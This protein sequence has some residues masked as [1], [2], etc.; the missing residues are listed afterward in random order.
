MTGWTEFAQELDCW[1]DQRRAAIFWWR[2]DDAVTATP[3]LGRLMAL[4]QEY[5]VPVAIAVIPARADETLG[6]PIADG[7]NCVLQHGYAHRNHGIGRKIELGGERPSGEVAEELLLGR[8]KL[9]DLLGARVLPVLV[10]PW[11]RIDDS[12]AALLP[13]LGYAGLSAFAPRR[14]RGVDG[15]VT[16]NTHIDIIDWRK[17]RAFCGEHAALSAAI[18]HLSAKRAGSA[19]PLEPTGLLTHHLA[20]DGECWAFMDR[21]LAETSAHAGAQWVSAPQ[22]FGVAA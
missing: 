2:D 10:P 17:T 22:A 4:Q 18:G 3:A 14:D 11:N 20:H 16:V 8:E 5:Q 12:I 13:G 1:R 6:D 9:T 15:F 21:F 7:D 19:D